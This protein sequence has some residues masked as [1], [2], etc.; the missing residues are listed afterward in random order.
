MNYVEISRVE[1]R[2][3]LRSISVIVEN[4]WSMEIYTSYAIL[5]RAA[6][7]KRVATAYMDLAEQGKA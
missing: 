6:S 1:E 2:V 3:E 5:L 4:E 7:R